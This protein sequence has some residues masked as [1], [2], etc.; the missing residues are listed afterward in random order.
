MALTRYLVA[1][2]SNLLPELLQLVE[3]LSLPIPELL[4]LPIPSLGFFEHLF[5]N[6]SGGAANARTGPGLFACERSP[7]TADGTYTRPKRAGSTW[8]DS[9]RMR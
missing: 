7:K 9:V 6:E 5:S 1:E 2:P 4:S 3:L 8:T